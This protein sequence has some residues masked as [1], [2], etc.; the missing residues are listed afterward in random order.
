MKEKKKLFKYLTEQGIH[1]KTVD[2]FSKV[3]QEDFIEKTMGMEYYQQA[4]ISIGCGEKSDDALVLA[5]M[6]DVLEPRKSWKLLEVGTGS[7]YS[8]AILSTMVKQVVTFE[9]H[10]TLARMAR[11]KL[12]NS[13]FFNVRSFAGDATE[14][15]D[16]LGYFDGLIIH[17]SCRQRPLSLLAILKEDHH[18]VFAMGP[19]IQQRIVK[20]K[21]TVIDGV[22]T[23]RNF[24]FHGYCALPSIR[25]QY[26]WVDLEPVPPE[27]E[28]EEEKEE[29]KE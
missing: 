7:G 27:P 21:N 23:F 22:D 18:A 1:K 8:T 19:V 13:G 3:N 28:G 11:E 16:E 10:E 20:Y 2:A 9:Y 4:P 29:N 5:R 25:G 17:A 14:I 6:I 24:T 26:G 15:M 12:V